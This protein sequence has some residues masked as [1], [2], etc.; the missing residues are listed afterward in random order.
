M[1]FQNDGGPDALNS[2]CNTYTLSNQYSQNASDLDSD[3]CLDVEQAEVVI[4]TAEV[5]TLCQ[6]TDGDGQLNLPNCVSWR[7]PGKK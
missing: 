2:S 3:A 4:H 6:D 7:Q 1:Y 5:T